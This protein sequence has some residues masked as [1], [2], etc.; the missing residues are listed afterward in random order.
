LSL[1]T[2]LNAFK[3]NVAAD[4][5]NDNNKN[6]KIALSTHVLKFSNNAV[7]YFFFKFILI[8]PLIEQ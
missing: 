4:F 2:L 5:I 7:K 1:S 8:L 6:I 3:R